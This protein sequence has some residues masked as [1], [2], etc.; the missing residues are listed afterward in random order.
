LRLPPGPLR[1]AP[2]R[3]PRRAAGHR[4][5]AGAGDALPAGTLI[6]AVHF[7]ELLGAINKLRAVLAM[8]AATWGIT[9]TAGGTVLASQLTTLRE[10]LA[11]IPGA[12]GFTTT[13]MAAGTLITRAQLNELRAAVRPLECRRSERF[14]TADAT[15]SRDGARCRPAAI[16]AEMAA[17]PAPLRRWHRAPGEWCA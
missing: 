17:M 15:G 2:A 3:A 13:P 9:P 4:P 7:T 8:S 6:K 14:D 12:T 10:A 1:R 5:D 11:A 16:R